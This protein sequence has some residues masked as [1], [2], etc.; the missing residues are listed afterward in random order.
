M[1]KEAAGIVI[2]MGRNAIGGSGN[3]SMVHTFE[4]IEKGT[5]ICADTSSAITAVSPAL[6]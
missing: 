4:L 6:P 2:R 1:S 3:Y 5:E